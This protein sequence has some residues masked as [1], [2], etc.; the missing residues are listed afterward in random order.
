MGN[1]PGVCGCAS[2]CGAVGD[3]AETESEGPRPTSSPTV[4][5][6]VS[7]SPGWAQAYESD[8]DGE[9]GAACKD[10]YLDFGEVVGA[11]VE[12]SVTS[13]RVEDSSFTDV[14]S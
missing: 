13:D 12:G 8:K 14:I 7:T 4:K 1:N 11:L 2:I 9:G 5:R 10:V 3:D 6:V